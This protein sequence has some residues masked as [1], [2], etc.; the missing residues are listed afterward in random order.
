MADLGGS[1]CVG[2]PGIIF[3]TC[4]F[5]FLQ[6]CHIQGLALSHLIFKKKK[7]TKKILPPTSTHA[8]VCK[9]GKLQ[10]QLQ[11]LEAVHTSFAGAWHAHFCDGRDDGVVPVV[12]A[13]QVDYP[14]CDIFNGAPIQAMVLS[15]LGVPERKWGLKSFGLGLCFV[16]SSAIDCVYLLSNWWH[17]TTKP[18]S[19]TL[20]HVLVLLRMHAAGYQSTR[21]FFDCAL[22]EADKHM[23]DLE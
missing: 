2:G 14:L 12:F 21:I 17:K 18:K 11:S 3:H 8:S 6:C 19:T 7:K 5:F 10:R 23:A 9:S 22:I 1:S 15:R 13:N 16:L 4:T 20:E